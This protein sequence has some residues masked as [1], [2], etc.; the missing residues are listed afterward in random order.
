MLGLRFVECI[1]CLTDI[2]TKLTNGRRFDFLFRIERAFQTQVL[3]W[4]L[5]RFVEARG[6]CK[7]SGPPHSPLGHSDARQGPLSIGSAPASSLQHFPF[8]LGKPHSSAHKREVRYL[9]F[10]ACAY[11][12]N[13]ATLDYPV[14]RIVIQE[15]QTDGQV[16]RGFEVEA[17]VG[18][19]PWS[20]VSTTSEGDKR[21]LQTLRLV[22]SFED[23]HACGC[24]EWRCKSCTLPTC[25]IK[26]LMPDRPPRHSFSN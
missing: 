26:R 16:I 12:Q 13:Y 15:D 3:L 14:D 5:R 22:G 21:L 9:T 7:I 6:H 17:Q 11:H 25:N 19:G 20:Q 23:L 1:R 2:S 8:W 18:T 24:S 10:L 4:Q